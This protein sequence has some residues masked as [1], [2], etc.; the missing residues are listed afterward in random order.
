MLSINI[1]A[2][3]CFNFVFIRSHSGIAHEDESISPRRRNIDL[4]RQELK[5]NCP[6]AAVASAPCALMH[7]K[8]WD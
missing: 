3:K 8:D 7:F 6:Q 1:I 5:I 2:F 4:H